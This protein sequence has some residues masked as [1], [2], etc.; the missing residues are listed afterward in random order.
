MPKKEHLSRRSFLRGAGAAAAGAIGALH[1]GEAPAQ[2][3]QAEPKRLFEADNLSAYE[4]TM[5]AK[6]LLERA[7][8]LKR[9]W[10]PVLDAALKKYAYRA[11]QQEDE[12]KFIDELRHVRSALSTVQQLGNLHTL[13][14]NP[15]Q[16][17][18]ERTLSDFREWIQDAEGVAKNVLELPNAPKYVDELRQYALGVQKS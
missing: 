10:E 3:N 12:Q 1:S 16:T 14:A 18:A 2:S 4:F 9:T 11:A 13:I 17:Q 7:D 6:E 5:R 15:Y 8:R